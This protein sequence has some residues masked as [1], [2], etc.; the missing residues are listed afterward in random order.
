MVKNENQKSYKNNNI[1]NQLNLMNGDYNNALNDILLLIKSKERNKALTKINELLKLDSLLNINTN[2]ALYPI[3][4]ISSFADTILNNFDT[5]YIDNLS[6]IQKSYN[7][8]QNLYANLIA[9]YIDST[10]V[11]NADSVN[12]QGQE[13]INANNV[14][15]SSISDLSTNLAEIKKP[16]FIAATKVLYPDSVRGSDNFFIKMNFKILE[17]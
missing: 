6:A 9:Y 2:Y 15:V 5:L 4:S 14:M 12:Q 13:T 7:E 17:T 16:A 8:R 3:Y 1:L 11:E 10:N